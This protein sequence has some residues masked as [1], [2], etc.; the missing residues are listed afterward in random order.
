[1]VKIRMMCVQPI[2]VSV[3]Q[4][5]NLLVRKSHARSLHSRYDQ[6]PFHTE[7][8]Q[9]F[10][11]H[12]RK[13]V[14]NKSLFGEAIQRVDAN[15]LKADLAQPLFHV[16]G[17]HDLSEYLI[18]EETVYDLVFDPRFF[19]FV[20]VYELAFALPDHKLGQILTADQADVRQDDFYNTLRRL[21]VKE[22]DDSPL[23]QWA[24]AIRQQVLD[25][26]ETTCRAERRRNGFKVANI[27]NNSGN[28]TFFVDAPVSDTRVKGLFLNCNANA[29]R[30]LGNC[31]TVVDNDKVHYAFFSRFHTIIS[32]DPRYYYRYAPIQ[33]HIQFIW[34][35][36]RYYS[37]IMEVLNHHVM[38]LNSQARIGSKRHVIDEYINK[39]EQLK[40]H[41][42]NFKLAIESDNTAVYAQIEGKWNIESSLANAQ[43]YV[44]FFKDYLE[45][46]Y[47]RKAER[48]SQRQ[49]HILF[50]ISCIQ[51]LGLISIWS[52][53]LGLSKLKHAV[54]GTELSHQSGE[55]WLLHFNTWLPIALF[56]SLIALVVFAYFKSD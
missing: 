30:L 35:Y 39:I 50:V 51:I 28:I 26:V 14:N 22:R 21:M 17:E 52:D 56:A 44:S 55:Y 4:Y 8:L 7:W 3:E 46:A 37:E 40:M 16:G 2:E 18:P 1:M 31:T 5:E 36:V 54:L 49:N 42:E 11:Q 43:S 24:V 45:R 38:A 32:D 41:N 53:Y 13:F 25:T 48:A 23:S 12:H 27:G 6:N 47:I 15:T 29:E 10:R 9:Q 19:N 33:Y 34:F 20:L